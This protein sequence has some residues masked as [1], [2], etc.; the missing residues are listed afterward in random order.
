MIRIILQILLLIFVQNLFGQNI[1]NY[2]IIN[3]YSKYKNSSFEC[4]FKSN[5]KAILSNCGGLGKYSC[6]N[7]LNSNFEDDSTYRIALTLL[8][9]KDSIVFARDYIFEGKFEIDADGN[10]LLLGKHPFYSNSIKIK[11]KKSKD[12]IYTLRYDFKLNTDFNWANKQ[13]LF[14][15]CDGSCEIYKQE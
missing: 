8:E 7:S 9:I 14:A 15:Y 2:S 3:P 11:E 1:A 13:K 10:I 6:F 12:N 5:D 4:E